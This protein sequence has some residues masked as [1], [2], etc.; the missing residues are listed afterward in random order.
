MYPTISELG[1]SVSLVRR[2]ATPN[3]ESW[4]A[5]NPSIMRTP[6][7]E[8]WMAFRSSNYLLTLDG[9][10]RLTAE[11]KIRNKIYLVRL[12]PDTWEFDESTLKEIDVSHL[13]DIKRN[14]ED[15]RLFWDGNN[16]CISATFLEVHVPTA[17][18]CKVVLESLENPIA[19][20]LEIFESPTGKVEKNW[21]PIQGTDDFIYSS[22]VLFKSRQFVEMDSAKV[23]KPFRG[24]TQ[25]ISL[26]DGTSIALIH[27]LY[28]RTFASFN[29]L[30]FAQE[31]S[32]RRYTHCFVMFDENYKIIKASDRFIF[33]DE[34]IEFAS[35][36][37]EYKDGY[38]I[39]FGRWDASTYIA[40]I[41]KDNLLS[42][43]KDLD[44]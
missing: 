25:V 39:S 13:A 42:T 18:L 7:D 5:Y 24:G 23:A 34:G 32:S 33:I 21:M 35:G 10:I 41:N 38:A 36:I 29:P 11:K 20:S 26:G 2:Y 30:N 4:S 16:Y 37:T 1:G 19:L 31:R 40:T 27:E 44:V 17:R 3:D 6:N 28:Y 12:I 22:S 8:Y 15:P 43:L 14:I 9:N